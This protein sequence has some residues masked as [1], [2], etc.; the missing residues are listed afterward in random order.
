MSYVSIMII[1]DEKVY[2]ASV[3]YRKAQQLLWDKTALNAF[4]AG[5]D[6]HYIDA[7]YL[8]LDCDSGEVINRQMAFSE[9]I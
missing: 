5:C 8:V 3:H 1:R 2:Y 9:G 6:S 7:G 4:L